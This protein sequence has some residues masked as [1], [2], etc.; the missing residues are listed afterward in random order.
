MSRR[1]DGSVTV[2]KT[3]VYHVEKDMRVTPVSKARRNKRV[4]RMKKVRRVGRR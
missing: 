2:P 3:G 4:Q 1:K